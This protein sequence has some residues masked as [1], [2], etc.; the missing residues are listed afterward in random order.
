MVDRTG[1]TGNFDFSVDL[2]ANRADYADLNISE[3]DAVSLMFTDAVSN[4]GLKFESKKAP[5][6]VLVIDHVEQPDAN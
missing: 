6:E 4:L 5:V 3:R 1:L 2:S